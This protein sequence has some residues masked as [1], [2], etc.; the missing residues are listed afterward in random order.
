MQFANK[1]EVIIVQVNDPIF[2]HL[3]IAD[4]INI[5]ITNTEVRLNNA[6]HCLLLYA[7]LFSHTPLGAA[8]ASAVSFTFIY[9]FTTQWSLYYKQHI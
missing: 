8:V 1:T 2:A 9:L 7:R 3:E 6:Q 4:V 5:Q